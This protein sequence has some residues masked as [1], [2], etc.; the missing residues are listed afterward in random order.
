ME[1]TSTVSG[2][3]SSVEMI[4]PLGVAAPLQCFLIVAITTSRRET[5]TASLSAEAS[6]TTASSSAVQTTARS[7]VPTTTHDSWSIL[8]G[9]GSNALNGSASNDEFGLSRR[10]CDLPWQS[11]SSCTSS[12]KK[13]RRVCKA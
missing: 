6:P 3:G 8:E 4:P 7:A 9:A 1:R 2:V 11:S 12:W 13:T 10:Q 5:G